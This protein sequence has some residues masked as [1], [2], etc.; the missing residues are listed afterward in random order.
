[1]R[2][3]APPACT[4][5]VTVEI[6]GSL[7]KLDPHRREFYNPL[8]WLQPPGILALPFKGDFVITGSRKMLRDSRHSRYN[9]K[10]PCTASF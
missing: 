3:A 4:R 1:V 8:D 10:W 2:Q 9:Q 5:C 7:A 6:I